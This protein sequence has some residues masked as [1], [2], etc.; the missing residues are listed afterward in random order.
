FLIIFNIA[1]IHNDPPYWR[2]F[3]Y[4]MI[5]AGMVWQLAQIWA[6]KDPIQRAKAAGGA[7]VI[8]VFAA[9]QSLVAFVYYFMAR[10][11]MFL[12]PIT[13]SFAFW[14]LKPF[15]GSNGEDAE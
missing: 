5:N 1:N 12:S 15:M 4:L 6:N 2:D 14:C 8:G 11:E 13:Q 7:M 9:I 3:L 10:T